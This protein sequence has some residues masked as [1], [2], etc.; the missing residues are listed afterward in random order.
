MK[1]SVVGGSPVQPDPVMVEVTT[2]ALTLADLQATD[3]GS[4]TV[5]VANAAGSVTG[6]VA[7]LTVLIPPA[8]TTQPQAQT[9]IVG[10]SATFSVV[11]TGSAPLGYQWSRN[12]TAVSGATNSMLT[13]NTAQ[14]ADAGS[15]TVMVTDVAGSVP[16]AVTTLTVIPPTPPSFDSAGMTPNGFAFQLSV[17]VGC[18]YVILATTNLQDWTPISTNVALTGSVVVTDPAATNCSRQF[19]RAMVQ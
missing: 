4:Y 10:Q 14:S 15:Y 6:A 19:Y 1:V 11:A 5:V 18:T 7:T 13:L 2:S 8:I 17:P 3:A 12:G 16:S 9:V